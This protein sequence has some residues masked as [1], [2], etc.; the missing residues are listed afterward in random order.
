[1]SS[2]SSKDHCCTLLAEDG[3]YPTLT[4]ISSERAELRACLGIP[5]RGQQYE[6]GL[7]VFPHDVI[8]NRA[9]LLAPLGVFGTFARMA[10]CSCGDDH[11]IAGGPGLL[12]SYESGHTRIA[13]SRRMKLVAVFAAAAGLF[14]Q[15][16]Q[17]FVRIEVTP[18]NGPVQGGVMNTG[19]AT[20]NE[21]S[22][23][24]I[25]RLDLGRY[26]LKCWSWSRPWPR[27]T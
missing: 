12:D 9:V 26:H 2:P 7:A 5:V 15:D 11:G 10:R 14:A 23:Y 13:G 8:G 22:E 6:V 3:L 21:K 4:R 16:S 17:P 25:A 20:T 18:E 27:R 1:M 19:G 24:Q